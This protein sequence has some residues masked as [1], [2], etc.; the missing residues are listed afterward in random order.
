MRVFFRLTKNKYIRLSGNCAKFFANLIY[1]FTRKA[2]K[3][4]ISENEK[5]V[6]LMNL[7]K[8]TLAR[9]YKKLYILIGHEA[10]ATG[11]P[12]VLM[13]LAREL[14]KENGVI[15]FLNEYSSQMC[16]FFRLVKSSTSI[17]LSIKETGRLVL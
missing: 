3:E 12:V 8:G 11:A 15:I 16:L 9:N 5:K 2:R 10:S 17:D 14:S 6:E 13:E 1:K 4:I 7:Y